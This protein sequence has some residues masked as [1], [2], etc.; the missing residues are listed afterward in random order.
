MVTKFQQILIKNNR[1]LM[2]LVVDGFLAVIRRQRHGE[3]K[4]PENGEP[5]TKVGEFWVARTRSKAVFLTSYD[6]HL[7]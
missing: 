4:T 3:K 1:Y 6:Y 2:T 5:R 7:Y